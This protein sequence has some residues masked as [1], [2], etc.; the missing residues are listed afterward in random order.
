VVES[1]NVAFQPHPT[2]GGLRLLLLL[3]NFPFLQLRRL[4]EKERHSDDPS[5]PRAS[6]WDCQVGGLIRY[7]CRRVANAWDWHVGRRRNAGE[8]RAEINQRD[9]LY[10]GHS[11]TP[12]RRADVVKLLTL[13]YQSHGIAAKLRCHA[14][15]KH[16]TFP[17]YCDST[18]KSVILHSG[19]QCDCLLKVLPS[20]VQ[21]LR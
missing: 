19:A 12:V 20:L 14:T 16:A 2:I 6:I 18:G 9:R 13:P 4:L 8:G 7:A 5:L 11:G 15:P 10:S 1:I 17:S 21:V 3:A